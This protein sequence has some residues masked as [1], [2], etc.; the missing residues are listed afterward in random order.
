MVALKRLPKGVRIDR[1]EE[2]EEQKLWRNIQG[3][4]GEERAKILQELARAAAAKS[5]SREALAL[6]QEAHQIYKSL[7][8]TAP[9]IDLAN[10]L[11]GIAELH[12]KLNRV[13][14]AIESLDLAIEILK[15]GRYPHIA[16]A[17]RCKGLW[18]M[19]HQEF[20]RALAAYLEA[21]QIDE[22]EGDAVLMAK[23]LLSVCFCFM[24]L[25]QWDEVIRHAR[26]ARNIAQDLKFIMDVAWSD[27]F[28]GDAYAELGFVGMSRNHVRKAL[29][30][31]SL[32]GNKEI[33][34]LSTLA[35][36]K[37]HI[38]DGD[39]DSAE[40]ELVNARE[41]A[42]QYE[43]WDAIAK[44]E[45]E[46]IAVLRMRGEDRATEDARSRLETLAEITG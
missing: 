37:C 4:N 17:I 35:L 14:E 38:L 12:Q 13:D 6:A 42:T 1:F 11:I 36:A 24:K 45:R 18:L 27:L 20:E 25:G 3:T 8:A 33:I 28:M 26:Q 23:D 2:S 10:S 44:I 32:R 30:V 9:T 19:S 46:Y 41:I 22:I 21:V 5:Q 29:D 34:C 15:D 40:V 7:G 31:A 16:T 39:L 43:D